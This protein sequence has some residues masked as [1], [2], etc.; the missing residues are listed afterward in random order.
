MG[1]ARVKLF[2]EKE[3]EGVSTLFTEVLFYIFFKYFFIFLES[4]EVTLFG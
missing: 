3:R 1:V 4:P 2:V